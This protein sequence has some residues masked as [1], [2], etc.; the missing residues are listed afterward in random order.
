MD[1]LDAEGRIW[2]PD[3]MEKRPRLKRYLEEMPGTLIG[4]VWSDINPI[5]SQ[6][7][8]TCRISDTEARSLVRP[9]PHGVL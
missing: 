9:H 6:A 4:D 8:R 5:N 3:S 7:A 2:Y 1:E